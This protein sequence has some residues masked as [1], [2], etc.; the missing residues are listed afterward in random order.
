VRHAR[1]RLLLTGYEPFGGEPVNPSAQLVERLAARPPDTQ[2]FEQR[3]VVLPVAAGRLLG[4][5]GA[6]LAAW[7]PDVLLAVGQATGRHRV[8][9]E[10]VARNMLD[11][12]GEADND[13]HVADGE[14]L[15]AD[16]PAELALRLDVEP[17]CTALAAEGLP[18]GVSRDAGR[19]LCNALLYELLLRH[20]GLP[21]LFV[22]VPLLPEQ[23]ARRGRGEASLPADTSAACVAALISRLPSLLPARP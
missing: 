4:A 18:I 22:H 11:T 1:R 15:V 20:P 21:S 17:A 16:G 6:A 7:P 23:A 2:P 3:A 19:H 14:V 5:L 8:E 10:L 12:R 13:G 9:V